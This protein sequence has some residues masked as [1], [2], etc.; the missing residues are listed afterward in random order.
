LRFR[1]FRCCRARLGRLAPAAYERALGIDERI[2]GPDHPNVAIRVNNLGTVLRDLG[3]LAGA[4]A[5]FE[6]A[7][8]IREKVFGREH[9]D[10]ALT[11]WWLGTLA[12]QA[13]DIEEARSYLEEA[14]RTF[15]KNLPAEHSTIAQVRRDLDSLD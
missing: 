15:G 13:G 2:Y 10:T 8:G 3:D 12:T 1:I 6:R 7:L 11:L 5:A 14:L 9:P 4:R